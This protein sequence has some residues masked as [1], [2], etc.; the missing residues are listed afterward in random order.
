[1][2]GRYAY[3]MLTYVLNYYRLKVVQS[4]STHTLI[5]SYVLTSFSPKYA[6]TIRTYVLT[7]S[8]SPKYAYTIR[9]YVL[10][11]FRPTLYVPI[12][13]THTLYVPMF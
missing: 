6:Y 10:T 9:T 5:R 3:T 2:S 4:Q 13:S 1:M 7:S 8:T 12:P 11:S